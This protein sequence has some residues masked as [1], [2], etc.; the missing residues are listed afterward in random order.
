M[1]A[2]SKEL[3]EKG[4][5]FEAEGLGHPLLDENTG[6]RND[7]QLGDTVRFLIV[8]LEVRDYRRRPLPQISTD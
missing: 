7:L 2:D 1:S 6:V 5:V 3:V 4:P 8:S